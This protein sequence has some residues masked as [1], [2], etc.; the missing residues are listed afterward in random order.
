MKLGAPRGGGRGRRGD[1]TGRC[2][3]TAKRWGMAAIDAFRVLDSCVGLAR[4]DTRLPPEQARGVAS[5]YVDRAR[6]MLDLAERSGWDDAFVLRRLAWMFLD[7]ESNEFHDPERAAGHGTGLELA[8]RFVDCWKM[9]GLA[10]YR[11][12][13]WDGAIRAVER[14]GRS[15]GSW[16][17][18]CVHAPG[19]GPRAE[20]RDGLGSRVLRARPEPRGRRIE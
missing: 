18:P 11:G 1:G 13:D 17:Y 3:L 15:G 10:R 5:G 8:P 14:T 7:T 2:P 9:L 19:R 20:G 16:I 6:A 4:K 12:G